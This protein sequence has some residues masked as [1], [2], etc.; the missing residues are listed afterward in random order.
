MSDTTA[1][2]FA[3]R[4]I[5]AVT[6]K[7]VS[8]GETTDDV[9]ELLDHL[10]GTKLTIIGRITRLDELGRELIRQYDWLADLTPPTPGRRRYVVQRPHGC[11]SELD[12]PT[13]DRQFMRWAI[14]QEATHPSTL[15]VEPLTR[16]ETAMATAS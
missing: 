5:L 10:A 9:T 12:L 15:M 1:R 7:N 11:T 6:T 2:P 8:F 16:T 13:K 14:G 4:Y 3:L